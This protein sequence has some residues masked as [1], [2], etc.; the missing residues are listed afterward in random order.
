MEHSHDG[1]PEFDFNAE[2]ACEYDYGAVAEGVL[3][4]VV[5]EFSRRDWRN[6]SKLG[7]EFDI[8]MTVE[9]D[10]NLIGYGT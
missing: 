6:E 7:D 3:W 2:A 5:D 9:Q 8:S 10:M 4:P 1:I